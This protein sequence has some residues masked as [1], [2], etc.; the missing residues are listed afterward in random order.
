MLRSKNYPDG[1]IWIKM[2]SNGEVINPYKLIPPLYEDIED[3]LKK[4]FLMKGDIREGGAAMT[5]FG[6]MQFANISDFE[7]ESI[8]QG[9]LKYCELDTM[10]MVLIWE[11]WHNLINVN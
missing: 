5:A 4:N 8:A 11:Y 7:R 3:T 1:W 6:L 2:D 9:L 10:A